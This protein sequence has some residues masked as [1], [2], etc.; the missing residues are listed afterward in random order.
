VSLAG[1]GDVAHEASQPEL[2]QLEVRPEAG[3]AR[4]LEKTSCVGERPK[5]F[6][7]AASGVTRLPL[8]EQTLREPVKGQVL[9]TTRLLALHDGVL[10]LAD[11]DDGEHRHCCRHREDHTADSPQK[12]PLPLRLTADQI[13]EADAEHGSEYD[14]AR[15]P[16]A[17]TGRFALG[18]T[19]IDC[20]RLAA[21]LEQHGREGCPGLTPGEDKD[22]VLLPGF[23]CRSIPSGFVAPRLH[24]SSM[25]PRRAL[26][27]GRLVTQ[28]MTALLTG[29]TSRALHVRL[30][31]AILQAMR[32]FVVVSSLVCAL[33]SC[34]RTQMN[35][36]ATGECANDEWPSGGDRSGV[37]GSVGSG[38]SV[39]HGA[40]TGSGGSPGAG[41]AASAGNI[42]NSGGV[43]G[44][45]TMGTGGNTVAC[46][47]YEGHAEGA[48]SGSGWVELGSKDIVTSP[49]CGGQPV[50]HELVCPAFTWP[51]H[52][53]LCVSGVIPPLPS[54]PTQGDLLA[55]WGIMVGTD[56]SKFDGCTLGRSYK[57]ISFETLGSPKTELRASIH[58]HGYPFEEMYCA[59]LVSNAKIPFAAF[60]RCW[61]GSGTQLVLDDVS[62]IDKIAIQIVSGPNEIKVSSFC[63]RAIFLE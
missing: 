5:A 3:L 25:R 6:I 58:L 11:R 28:N 4:L 63:L 53:D 46:T 35:D 55:N 12:P 60:K 38:G 62:M 54:T 43:S 48:L 8:V 51:T 41:A 47:F 7:V 9:A 45:C 52:F 37:G 59:S 30:G 27:A 15:A 1:E 50:T 26:P 61:D 17:R 21:L 24:T 42:G 14:L 2:E 36:C 13:V 57:A 23:G 22:D 33:A 49:T 32:A 19:H 44:G 31:S 20:E 34:G 10:S 29:G 56:V 18:Q 16:P 39:G 40:V